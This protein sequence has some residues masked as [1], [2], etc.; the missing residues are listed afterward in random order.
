MSICF[1][2]IHKYINTLLHFDVRGEHQT[3]GANI[4]E[5]LIPSSARKK[6]PKGCFPLGLFLTDTSDL[7]IVY[8]NTVHSERGPNYQSLSKHHQ[9]ELQFYQ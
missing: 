9:R 3:F 4:K 8:H 2:I 6:R 5:A 1:T 7:E